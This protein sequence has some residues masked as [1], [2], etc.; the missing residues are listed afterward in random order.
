MPTLYTQSKALLVI[1]Q[2]ED[3]FVTI[4]GIMKYQQCQVQ[5]QVF[6]PGTKGIIP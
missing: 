4:K 6:T 2:Q 3:K 5:L 1:P